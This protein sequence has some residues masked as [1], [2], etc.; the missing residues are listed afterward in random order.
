MKSLFPTT[1]TSKSL[2]TKRSS[3]LTVADYKGFSF[4]YL[5]EHDKQTKYLMDRKTAEGSD[6][7]F[8]RDSSLKRYPPSPVAAGNSHE[9][10]T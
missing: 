7:E 8:Q 6:E 10:S 5:A 9:V 4:K 2:L 1:A 3:E